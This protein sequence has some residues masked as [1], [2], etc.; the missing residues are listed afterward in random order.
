MPSPFVS[1]WS[2]GLFLVLAALAYGL[3]LAAVAY[4]RKSDLPHGIWVLV[5]LVAALGSW[6]DLFGQPLAVWIQSYG[7]MLAFVP[8]IV[9]LAYFRFTDRSF[10]M[11]SSGAPSND[12]FRYYLN[13]DV[14]SE[15][16]ELGYVPIGGQLRDV[17]VLFTDVR[18]STG[19]C[20]QYPAE[21][22]VRSLNLY[23]EAVC[24]SVIAH[25]GTVDKFMGDGVIAFFNA[26]K[27]LA[28]H[29]QAAYDA[30]RNILKRMVGVNEK[31]EGRGLPR[32]DVGIGLDTGVGVVGNVGSR[33]LVNYTVIGDVANTA[34]RGQQFAQAGQ[35]AL[36][37]AVFQHLD[38]APAGIRPQS[39]DIKGKGRIN[40]YKVSVG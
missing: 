5:L 35:I 36:T 1:L 17:T 7:L 12:F 25:G 4:R 3:A 30:S 38:D 8:L 18:N 34:A 14:I 27:K 26:P 24:E 10:F 16:K 9:F 11:T 32:L 33:H 20:L 29:P 19:L 2:T 21:T 22:V 31:L 39:V 6:W 40:V 23:Y 13:P 15:M 37:S 28:D